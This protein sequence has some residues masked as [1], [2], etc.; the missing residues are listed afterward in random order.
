LNTRFAAFGLAVLCLTLSAGAATALVVEA[1]IF[2]RAGNG[3]LERAAAIGADQAVG[4][5]SL[6]MAANL[7]DCAG[8]VNRLQSLEMRYLDEAV[9]PAILRNCDALAEQTAAAAPTNSFAWYVAA[10][11]AI[12]LDDADRFNANLVRSRMTG[13]TEQ[14]LADLRVALAETNLEKLDPDARAALDDDLRLMIASGVGLRRLA[15]RYIAHPEFRERLADVLETVSPGLQQRF[16]Y[17]L[18]QAV[19][20]VIAR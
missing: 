8:G 13:S 9:S 19:D 14:W 15:Q 2:F 7:G 17:N 6:S 16:L 1:G 5:S 11:T 10:L 3:V 18:D 4:L 20:D 12:E